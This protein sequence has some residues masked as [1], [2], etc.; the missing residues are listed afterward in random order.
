MPR[1]RHPDAHI[2]KALR[3]A[4]RDG[5]RV[6]LL[7]PR[8]HGWGK[9]YCPHNDPDCRCGEFCVTVV[10]GTPRRPENH[11]RQLR[12]VVD[13]CVGTRRAPGDDED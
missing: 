4:E 2:E 12:R 1:R 3:Y 13:G 10:W 5:W 8:A 6:E 11:A 9:M 7:G